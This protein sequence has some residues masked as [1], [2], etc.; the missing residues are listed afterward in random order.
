MF[1]ESLTALTAHYMPTVTP[2]NDTSWI[3]M[4]T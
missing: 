1:T 3:D 2:C 4:G